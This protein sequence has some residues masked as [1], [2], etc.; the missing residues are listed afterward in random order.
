MSADIVRRFVSCAADNGID[1]FRLH[2]PLND[3]SNLLE[4][5]EAIVAAGKEF[6]VGLVYSAGRVGGLD[7]LVER[8]KQIPELGATR[9][10]LN[11]PTDALLPS[12]HRRAGGSGSARRR[13]CPSGCSSKGPR[14]RGS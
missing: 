1:V 4:A 5:G 3:V 11:D 10:I 8:A 2:D 6:H 13:D 12:P 14:A 7:A 9:V